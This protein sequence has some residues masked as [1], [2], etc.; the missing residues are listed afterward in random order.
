MSD[1]TNKIRK[2]VKEQIEYDG[3][4]RM[5]REIERKISGGETPISD[6]PALP[7]KEN[8]EFDKYSLAWAGKVQEYF[9]KYM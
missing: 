5:D 7:G 8:D 9:D 6:N 4:E 1:L 3:P 2:A